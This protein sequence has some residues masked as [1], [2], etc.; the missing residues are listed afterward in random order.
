[1]ENKISCTKE[2]IIDI[3]IDLL[4]NISVPMKLKRE[5]S[6]PLDGA[7]KNLVIVLQMMNEEAMQKAQEEA[8]EKPE[9]E[10]P[11]DE[12][13]HLSEAGERSDPE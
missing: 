6:D 7:I 9:E 12:T 2:K 8:A 10:E 4:E 1:M 3:T 5:I 11:A 13:E